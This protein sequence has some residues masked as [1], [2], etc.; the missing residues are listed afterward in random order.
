MGIEAV[1]AALRR[2]TT[3]AAW[4]PV[5]G[6]APTTPCFRVARLYAAATAG[7]AGTPSGRAAAA[8]TAR[9]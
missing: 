5:P 6:R 3:Y 4:R 1:Q 9:S 7:T 2:N 8:A